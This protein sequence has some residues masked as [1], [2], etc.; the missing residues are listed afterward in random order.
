MI[1]FFILFSGLVWGGGGQEDFIYTLTQG[2]YAPEARW[3]RISVLDV[4]NIEITNL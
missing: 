1:S 2:M 4:L 3:A